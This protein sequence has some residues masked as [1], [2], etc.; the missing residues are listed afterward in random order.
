MTLQELVETNWKICM[1]SVDVRDYSGNGAYLIQSYHIGPYE[2]EDR[3][4]NEEFGREPRWITIR[5]PINHKDMGKDYWGVIVKNIPKKLLSLEV[6]HWDLWDGWSTNNGLDK[7]MWLNVH[8]SGN[9]EA[10]LVEE[11]KPAIGQNCQ[12]EGQMWIEDLLDG[13]KDLVR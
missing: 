3:Y 13:N 1:I 11:N 10:V 7:H 4:A 8:V 12:I 6:K 9:D 2:D 5:K